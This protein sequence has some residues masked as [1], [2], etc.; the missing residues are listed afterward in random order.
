M[1]TK[2]S[3]LKAKINEDF[4]TL[5][6][7]S[8]ISI[9]L[10]IF[11]SSRIFSLWDFANYTDLAVRIF[12]KQVP[13]LDIPL[14]TQPGSFVDIAL[15]FLL[16][17]KNVQG[18]YYLIFLKQILIGFFIIK[19]LN[20]VLDL[21]FQKKLF[22][23]IMIALV[24]SWSI[25]P[26][27]T[28]DADLAFALTF[29]TWV[30]IRTIT[31]SKI[32]KF[33]DYFLITISIW[34][35]F[36]YKQ[37]SGLTWLIFSHIFLIIFSIKLKRLSII[38]FIVLFEI[39]LFS[40]FYFINN[41]TDIF[42]EWYKWAVQIPL[43]ARLTE[44][45]KPLAQ[46]IGLLDFKDLFLYILILSLL[47]LIVTKYIWNETSRV[48]FLFIS[49]LIIIIDF[50]TKSWG[51][52]SY[53]ELNWDRLIAPTI[54]VIFI[55]AFISMIFDKEKNY[56]KLINLG[57]IATLASNYLAQGIVGSSYAFF[58]L[59]YLI[60]LLSTNNQ[61]KINQQY[62]SK[63][64]KI[65]A[66]YFF[67]IVLITLTVFF[68]SFSN[69]RMAYVRIDEPINRYP[70]LYGWIGM[71]G[72]YLEET[73]IGI[74]LFK[75]YSR[76]DSTAV[77][78]GEDPVSLFSNKIPATEVSLSDQTTNPY[79]EDV[80]AWLNRNNI[81]FVILKTR[82]QTPGQHQIS[83]DKF[84]EANKDFKQ[85]KQVGVYLVLERIN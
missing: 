18:I 37:S 79:Y 9:F 56:L 36:W 46:L 19:I 39:F 16:F 55:Y 64:M 17:G 22:L 2:L 6:V 33:H 34:L 59:Y 38:K 80:R 70:K 72:N 68:Y 41:Q 29:A 27:P 7:F 28:Y 3:L 85:I 81:R 11:Q 71:P 76:K 62:K 12:A 43:E 45:R 50:I 51:K 58:P 13:Y 21:N 74:D 75:E 30:L 25:V 5:L 15:S 60:I 84:V 57:L 47:V 66:I 63:T 14:Y 82:L 52:R 77:W 23:M 73:Q 54:V 65:N 78:P 26:Q 61:F 20:L 42:S 40:I 31:H 32:F 44:N 53:L 10:V 35:P 8:I 67:T 24:N 69:I 49:I 83:I 1:Q 4:I 48:F